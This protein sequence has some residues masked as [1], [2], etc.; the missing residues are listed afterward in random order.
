VPH[1]SAHDEPF[2]AARDDRA[3]ISLCSAFAPHIGGDC[4]GGANIPTGATLLR[5]SIIESLTKLVDPAATREREEARRG[6]R[7]APMRDDAGSPPIKF[8]CRV[9]G[10]R[11][12]EGP[13]CP[14]C[15]AATMERVPRQK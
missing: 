6:A 5:V 10:H 4:R 9:C 7:E 11:S 14:R 3:R 12:A 15:L 13:F 2:R 1:A 8:E